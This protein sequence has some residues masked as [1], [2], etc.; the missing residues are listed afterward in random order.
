L[1]Y[2]ETAAGGLL[3]SS[4]RENATAAMAETLVMPE[5]RNGWRACYG[6]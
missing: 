6:A 5:F 1:S 4:V 2:R 3:K